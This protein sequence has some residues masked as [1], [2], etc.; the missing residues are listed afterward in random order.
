MEKKCQWQT[1]NNL[2]ESMSAPT[3]LKLGERACKTNKPKS[4]CQKI[5]TANTAEFMTSSTFVWFFLIA[6][7]SSNNTAFIDVSN[8]SLKD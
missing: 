2:S 7:K 4:S 6:L 1:S 5:S 8:S 3:S